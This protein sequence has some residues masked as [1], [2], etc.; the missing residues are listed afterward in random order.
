MDRSKG[1]QVDRSKCAK[2]WHTGMVVS[3]YVHHDI[4]SNELNGTL[5]SKVASKCALGCRRLVITCEPSFLWQHSLAK[6]PAL[7]TVLKLGHR[8]ESSLYLTASATTPMQASRAAAAAQT[9]SPSI[10][11]CCIPIFVLVPLLS[12]VAPIDDCLLRAHCAPGYRQYRQGR[13]SPPRQPPSQPRPPSRLPSSPRVRAL[14]HRRCRS[15]RSR[16][17]R[18]EIGG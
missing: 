14:G 18:G 3:R 15:T 4:T 17:L 8:W 5:L 16:R 13:S 9:T 12:L 1:R 6:P 11:C 10:R 7:W 2:H